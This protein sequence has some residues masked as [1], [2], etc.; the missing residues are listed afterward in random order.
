MSKPKAKLTIID[1]IC[2]AISGFRG[3]LASMRSKLQ[4]SEAARTKA[5]VALKEAEAGI[6]RIARACEIKE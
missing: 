2:H 6:A 3:D 1:R 5:Q 4:S